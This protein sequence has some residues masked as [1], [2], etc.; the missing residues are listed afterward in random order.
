MVLTL[1]WLG[2]QLDI[3]WLWGDGSKKYPHPPNTSGTSSRP[4]EKSFGTIINVIKIGPNIFMIT[5]FFSV[6]QHFSVMTSFSLK[7]LAIIVSLYLLKR[8]LSQ[9]SLPLV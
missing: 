3:Q 2:F 4:W 6:R 8:L 5:S 9:N 1:F 7:V